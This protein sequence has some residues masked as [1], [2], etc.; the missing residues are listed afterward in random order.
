MQNIFVDEL[1]VSTS[2]QFLRAAFEAFGQVPLTSRMC[3]SPEV[4]RTRTFID[5]GTITSKSMGY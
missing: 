1:A 4:S 3:M 5:S 2:E